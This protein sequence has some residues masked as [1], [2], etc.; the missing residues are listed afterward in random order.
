MLSWI[1]FRLALEIQKVKFSMGAGQ[2]LNTFP[3]ISTAIEA[4]ELEILRRMLLV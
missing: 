2:N 3:A 1:E 4:I